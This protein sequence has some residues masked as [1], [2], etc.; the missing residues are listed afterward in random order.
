MHKRAEDPD[1][2][3]ELEVSDMLTHDREL[4]KIAG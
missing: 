2:K 1:P 4:I 3:W